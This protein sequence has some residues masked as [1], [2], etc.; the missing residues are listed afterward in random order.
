M[1]E[2]VK[3]YKK[4]YDRELRHLK[5]MMMAKKN[6]MQKTA[7]LNFVSSTKESILKNPE[8]FVRSIPDQKLFSDAIEQ[9]FQGFLDDQK[10]REVQK[11]F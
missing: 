6:T 4:I 5:V 10:I 1:H 11:K 3:E 9:V 7:W 8:N 2:L